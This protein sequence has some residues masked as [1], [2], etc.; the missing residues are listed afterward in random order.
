MSA[1]DVLADLLAAMTEVPVEEVRAVVDALSYRSLTPHL[2]DYLHEHDI[3]VA[4][5]IHRELG[6]CDVG[7]NVTHDSDNVIH[8]R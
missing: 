2:A 7:A 5:V 3:E 8:V 6:R 4:R 1:R